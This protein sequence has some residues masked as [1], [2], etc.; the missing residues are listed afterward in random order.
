MGRRAVIRLW[1]RTIWDLLRSAVRERREG[2]GQADGRRQRPPLLGGLG[3]DLLSAWR[4]SRRHPGSSAAILLL[5]ALGT[6]ACTSIFSLFN[7]VLLRP[8]PYQEPE[9][10]VDMWETYKV[11][12]SLSVSYPNFQDWEAQSTA[13][14]SMGAWVRLSFVVRGN[15]RAEQLGGAAVTAGIFEILGSNPLLGRFLAPQDMALAAAPA[16]VISEG[17]WRGRYASEPAVLGMEMMLDGKA[18]QIVG[19]MPASFRFPNEYRTEV[20]VP[21]AA[22]MP[23]ELNSR[24]SHPGSLVLARLRPGVSLE[25]A[26]QDMQRVT[27]QLQQAYPETNQENGAGM[28]L[29]QDRYVRNYRP[30]LRILLAGVG[31]LLLVACANLATLSLARNSERRREFSIRLVLGAARLRLIRQ[32]LAESLMMSLLGGGLGVLLALLLT[33]IGRSS[34]SQPLSMLG[35]GRLF[36]WKV[37]AFAL[38]LCLL[39][40]IVFGLAPAVFTS[41]MQAS[42]ALQVRSQ[43]GLRGASRLRSLL[44]MTEVALSVVLLSGA[45]LT[46]RS[47][48]ELF[49]VDAGFEVENLATLRLSPA[50]PQYSQDSQ[51]RA[52]YRRVMERLQQVPG[53][54]STAIV[55]P[56]P[57]VGWGSQWRLRFEGSPAVPPDERIR[58][59]VARVSEGYFRTMGIRVLEG[60]TF[61]LA[62]RG[63]DWAVIDATMAQKYYPDGALGRKIWAGNAALEVI[64]VVDHVKH[65]G[66][67]RESRIQLYRYSENGP[68]GGMSFVVRTQP[69]AS[70]LLAALREA[71]A[72]VEPMQPAYMLATMQDYYADNIAA[73]RLTA[74]LLLSFAA[75]ALLLAGLG[76]Y[77]VIAFVVGQSRG[78]IGVRLALGAS[79][80]SVKVRMI[81]RGLRHSL[82][83]I[84]LG[85]PSTLALG[86]LLSGQLHGVSPRDPFTLAGV[87]VV[88]CA[89]AIAAAWAPARRASRI[90]PATVL[91]W[92]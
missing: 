58:S 49:S 1:V 37:A 71:A 29:L 23:D 40:G 86:G 33:Q 65:Y 87:S 88:L 62:D 51:R 45:G 68:L 16:V 35:V 42:Q 28:R 20:W 53:V 85:V 84:A 80:R 50:G 55:H 59:D 15:E 7:A 19:V 27:R 5:V 34:L 64:G 46:L 3:Q 60:R 73:E 69:A 6:G 92:E 66:V 44:V 18:R 36:D 91:R 77:G 56:L 41:R 26:R 31:F 24:G 13:F 14:E 4:F 70:T 81:G 47:L 72:E 74:M 57:L 25:D 54:E 21:L 83:G 52:L 90:D 38:S 79:P 76:L 82:A 11:D 9:R 12:Q 75:F 22:E 67:N 8:L 61:T 78:E 10:L 30:A 17:L 43:L 63:S 2:P 89:L 48:S 39:T 32:V